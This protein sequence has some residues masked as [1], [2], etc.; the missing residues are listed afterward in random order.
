[1]PYTADSPTAAQLRARIGLAETGIA[2][3]GTMG[4]VS[5]TGHGKAGP[6]VALKIFTALSGKSYG[7][8]SKEEF[9]RIRHAGADARLAAMR[10][11]VA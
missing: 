4:V 2:N 3:R 1:M 7:G 9:R 5:D 8:K 6:T 10:K 11:R